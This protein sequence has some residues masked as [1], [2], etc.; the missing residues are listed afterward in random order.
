MP[1]TLKLGS[2]SQPRTCPRRNWS[3]S[4]NGPWTLIEDLLDL[5][6][7]EAGRLT[8]ERKRHPVTPL[9]QEALE[10]VEPMAAQKKLRLERE[11]PSEPLDFDCDRERVLQ[12]F[13]NLIGNAIK[14]TPEGGTIKVRAEMR[15]DETLFSVA[16]TGPGI[17]PD[18]LPHVFDR[19][20]QA[21]KTARLGTGLG[22]S[23]AEGLVEAHGG[24][25]W[26]E[27]TPGRGS[28]FF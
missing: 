14:F 27:S 24:H 12:V 13:G 6:S 18:E 25:I 19:Y 1:R 20:W 22:L 26:V 2:T 8:V 9:V 15:G 17:R 23:I 21:K 5:A 28:T 7:I 3:R 10:L 16:D 11:L 4:S